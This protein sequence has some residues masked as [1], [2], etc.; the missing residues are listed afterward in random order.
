MCVQNLLLESSS[1]AQLHKADVKLNTPRVRRA[2]LT[3]LYN[4]LTGKVKY[5]S[6]D[7]RF[8]EAVELNGGDPACQATVVTEPGFCTRITERVYLTEVAGEIEFG[9]RIS[10]EG[11]RMKGQPCLDC[12]SRFVSSTSYIFA[13]AAPAS[14]NSPVQA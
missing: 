2:F 7:G 6:R 11:R 9:G 1:A 3:R 13:G 10:P 14:V 5:W 8:R 4:A 12:P